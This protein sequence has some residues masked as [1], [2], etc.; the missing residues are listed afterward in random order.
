MKKIAKILIVLS[1]IAGTQI[2]YAGSSTVIQLNS[3]NFQKTI[4]SSKPV[5]VKF[6]ASWCGPCRK[7]APEYKKASKAFTG[8][9]VF[10]ELN[11]DRYRN[12]MQ[13]YRIQGVPTVV[14]FKNGK[15]LGRESGFY[16]SHD[17][18]SWAE[19]SLKQK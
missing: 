6:W 2:L 15:E 8:R 1:M 3:R 18:A 11:I 14:V 7:M 19:W 5:F 10:A 17:I 12:V 13:K 4:S 16:K 9:V